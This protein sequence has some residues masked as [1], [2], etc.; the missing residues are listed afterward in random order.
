MSEDSEEPLLTFLF[1]GQ[2]SCLVIAVAIWIAVTFGPLV[3]PWFFLVMAVGGL[4][5]LAR[6]YVGKQKNEQAEQ[7]VIQG[8]AGVFHALGVENRPMTAR[9]LSNILPHTI[10]DM[11]YRLRRLER[12]GLIGSTERGVS[13]YYYVKSTES[14]TTSGEEAADEEASTEASERSNDGQASERVDD[15]KADFEVE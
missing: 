5:G 8:E 3:E 4:F 9:E 6:A 10:Y 13:T 7:T 1:Y 14:S 12:K 11:K 15:E 2:L